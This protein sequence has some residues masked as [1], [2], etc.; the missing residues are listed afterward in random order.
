MTPAGHRAQTRPGTRSGPSPPPV[1]PSRPGRQA[2]LDDIAIAAGIGVATLYRHYPNRESLI[3]ACSRRFLAGCRARSHVG[4]ERSARS[5]GLRAV[6]NHLV[7]ILATEQG[8]AAVAG[9]LPAL[10]DRFARPFLDRLGAVLLRAQRQ[11]SIR[12]D[13][14]PVDL[15]PIMVMLVSTMRIPHPVENG[16]VTSRSFSTGCALEPLTPPALAA[17]TRR[18]PLA[19]LNRSLTR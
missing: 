4:G 7:T 3:A 15:A 12:A 6:L 18:H 9:S 19:A 8:L 2:H 11:G 14:A 10:T 16:F 17:P 5:D 1:P 13:A